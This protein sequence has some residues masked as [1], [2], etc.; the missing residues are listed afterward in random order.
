MPVSRMWALKV[1]RST[2]AATRRGSGNTV[3]PFGERQVGGDRDRGS[4][5]A[6]GDDLEQQFGAAWVDLDVAEFVE[7]EQVQAAVAGDDA[8]QDVV[9]RRPRR[10]R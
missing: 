4:F 2:I 1:T 6:F 5:F 10:V 7:A 9:R 8:G 3:A